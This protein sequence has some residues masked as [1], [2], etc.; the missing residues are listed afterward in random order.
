MQ[1]RLRNKKEK[2][3]QVISSHFSSGVNTCTKGSISVKSLFAADQTSFSFNRFSLA[4]KLEA[5]GN[6]TP[7]SL[8]ELPPEVKYTTHT[9]FVPSCKTYRAAL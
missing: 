4:Q 6:C 5:E 7:V 3:H 9:Y 1:W 2:M 8:F